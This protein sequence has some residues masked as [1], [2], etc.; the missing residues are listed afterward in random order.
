[1]EVLRNC[2]AEKEVRSDEIKKTLAVH[3]DRGVVARNDKELADAIHLCKADWS[4]ALREAQAIE[5]LQDYLVGFEAIRQ[6]V[7]KDGED[8]MQKAQN[9]AKIQK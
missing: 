8:A 1:M 4:N 7:I 6:N 2:V 9:T 5:T 3:K